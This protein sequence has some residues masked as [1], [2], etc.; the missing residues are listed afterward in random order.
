[1]TPA[2]EPRAAGFS[3][4]LAAYREMVAPALLA[5]LPER[6]P[7]RH[8][9]DLVREHLSHAGKG[10]RPALCLATARAFGG[11]AE[12]A[13]PSAV[14]LE[15]LHNA[16][17]VHDDVEDDSEFRRNQ[18]TM[19]AAHGVPLAVNTGDAMQ[20][21]SIRLLRDNLDL[22]GPVH[23]WAVI[24]EFDHMLIESL[25]GQAME[26]GWIRDNDCRIT[27]ENYLEMILK[28]TCWYSFIHPCRIGALVAWGPG[29]GDLARFDRFGY[30]VGAAFQIQDDILNLTG[31][32]HRYG[33]E[34]GGDLW[35]GKRTLMLSH[36]FGRLTG[37]DAA[38]LAKILAK[39]RRRRM[40]RE[41]DWLSA[42]L[43]RHG[44][45]D[46]AR[47]AAH[48]LAAAAERELD[49][50]YADAPEG[51]DKQFIREM[52]DYVVSRDV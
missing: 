24:Q 38:R 46:Y 31:E 14:A 42:M 34:I 5:A 26:L 23:T 16:F 47:G 35:E 19:Q 40:Q 29:G 13:L 20:A 11:R 36:L 9:Y 44:S 22:L 39:P 41:I 51:E 7:R 21:L 30:F 3:S 32:S 27:E 10:L 18:R 49:S 43:A 33:K 12:D 50:A 6:E 1:M 45:I 17:L 48:Q 37:D 52:V 15:L 2:S 8:L 25:E 4:K 28:K